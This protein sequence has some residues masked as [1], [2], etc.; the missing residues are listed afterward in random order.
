MTRKS[1]NI[2]SIVIP[3]TFVMVLCG[4]AAT[5]LAQDPEISSIRDWTKAPLTKTYGDWKH[6]SPSSAVIYWQTDGAAQTWV[7]YGKTRKY[8]HKTKTLERARFGHLHRLTGLET[9]SEYHY[10]LV[11]KGAHGGNL[12]SEDRTFTPQAIKGALR[13]P[14][15]MKARPVVKSKKPSLLSDTADKDAEVIDDFMKEMAPPKDEV[16]DDFMKEMAPPKM[17]KKPPF[18]LDKPG[19]T[20]VLTEDIEA[21][22]MAFDIKASNITLDL[23]GHTV[24]Y[25]TEYRKVNLLKPNTRK[26]AY[27]VI[28]RGAKRGS[29]R[30][31]NVKV[32]NG[33]IRQ[34]TPS[35][36]C[37]PIHITGSGNPELAGL[38]V[39]TLGDT[40]GIYS[41]WGFADGRIH[42]NV[43]LDNAVTAGGRWNP[44]I[45]IYLGA[46]TVKVDHNI[47]TGTFRLIRVS[48]GSMGDKGGAEIFE[49]DFYLDSRDS[50]QNKA[51]AVSIG[52][53]AGVARHNTIICEGVPSR[54][55]GLGSCGNRYAKVYSNR[56]AIRPTRPREGQLSS[57][58]SCVGI[59]LDGNGY[60]YDIRDNDIVV[61]GGS[62]KQ[63]R[64]PIPVKVKGKGQEM[65]SLPTTYDAYGIRIVQ[66]LDML[67]DSNVKSMIHGNKI[68]A[69]GDGKGAASCVVVTRWSFAHTLIFKENRLVS[70]WSNVVISDERLAAAAGGTRGC[71]RN[72]RFI[73]NTLVRHGDLK[74][75]K[76]VRCGLKKTDSNAVFIDTQFER[77]GWQDVGFVGDGGKREVIVGEQATLTVKDDK[78]KPVSGAEVMVED[79]QGKEYPFCRTSEDGTADIFVLQHAFTPEGKISRLPNNIRVRKR[80]LGWAVVSADAAAKSYEA[81]LTSGSPAPEKVIAR[82]RDRFPDKAEPEGEWDWLR[83][84][85]TRIY[86]EWKRESVTSAC[87]YWQT[88][89]RAWG[90]VEFGE[91]SNYGR[92]TEPFPKPNF[93]HMHH[94]TGLASKRTYHYRFVSVGVN[95]KRMVSEDKT[96]TTK[97]ADGMIKIPESIPGPPFVIEQPGNYLLTRDV[98]SDAGDVFVVKSEGVTLDLDG[99]TVVYGTE[100]AQGGPGKPARGIYCGTPQK[101]GDDE[102]FKPGDGPS[103]YNGIIL[104]GPHDAAFSSGVQFGNRSKYEVAGLRVEVRSFLTGAL[105]LTKGGR[106]ARV[107]HNL[108]WDLG[109]AYAHRHKQSRI[110]A[111]S[112]AGGHAKIHH[113]VLVNS[114]NQGISGGGNDTEIYENTVEIVGHSTNSQAIGGGRGGDRNIH[115]NRIVARGEHPICIWASST[116]NNKI[117]RN[118]VD[119][120]ADMRTTNEYG[121]LGGV[122]FRTDYAPNYPDLEFYDNLLV[123]R[124]IEDLARDY[125]SGGSWVFWMAAMDQETKGVFRNN[126]MVSM[127]Y[128]NL[129]TRGLAMCSTSPNLLFEKNTIMSNYR[130]VT[131]GTHRGEGRHSKWISNTFVKIGNHP[132]FTTFANDRGRFDGN[133]MIDSRFKD[134]ARYEMIRHGRQGGNITIQWH[135]DV[136]TE[137]G[138]QVLLEDDDL[139][140]V[141]DRKADDEGKLRAVVTETVLSWPE[142]TPKEVFNPYHIT[143]TKEGFKSC[144]KKLTVDKNM[145]LTMP[146]E[147]K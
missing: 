37:S 146:L 86:E 136:K 143:V 133:V 23:D 135:L 122:G 68:T 3:A 21:K 59:V 114:R 40:A 16:L 47:F 24:T 97:S 119:V 44:R 1:R 27:G 137:P 38:T 138:A 110:F 48:G 127:V 7:E 98:V 6:V 54:G 78:G 55:I 72:T 111:F 56:I 115:D 139:N 63:K 4:F 49:N 102:Y 14:Q 8:G 53:P 2:R 5:I 26:I 42:H 125:R 83:V 118:K 43:L 57:F 106:D 88:D 89:G 17:E 121:I 91:D 96:F 64:E 60:G 69:I 123:V 76:V 41:Q 82:L 77:T 46:I 142:K 132:K 108:L 92:H 71:G 36:W 95:G 112:G 84:P 10:R 107:H 101:P 25:N 22:D 131:L 144:V 70:N 11:S 109:H 30:I 99:H 19:A 52:V 45:C 62:Y 103:I 87:V 93:A 65:K 120:C 140:T 75:F 34:G 39:E 104:E 15:D 12:S 145:E 73:G 90:Y 79:K 31:G 18:V 74:E 116:C 147:K 35:N 32:F 129:A 134:G 51:T 29:P 105:R 141:F 100:P 9:G 28:L 80:G 50:S 128:G 124:T 130:C 126:T 113:N 67:F 94:L 13:I 20:Y 58:D 66:M 33:I 81:V 61:Y 117:Y 85:L